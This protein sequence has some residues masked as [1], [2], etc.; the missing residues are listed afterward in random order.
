M[1]CIQYVLGIA[2]NGSVANI[3]EN[4]ALYLMNNPDSFPKFC[5]RNP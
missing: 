5:N 3:Y 2:M 1:L 4:Y